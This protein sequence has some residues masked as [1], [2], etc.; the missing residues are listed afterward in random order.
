M[1]GAAALLR[2][3]HSSSTCEYE[4][5]PL[6]LPALPL[7][8]PAHTADRPAAAFLLQ[9]FLECICNS[10][11][12]LPEQQL[13]VRAGGRAALPLNV[14]EQVSIVCPSAAANWSH[15]PPTGVAAQLLTVQAV[16]VPVG[17]VWGQADPW[18]HVELGRQLA[19]YPSG[20]PAAALYK[21]HPS[22]ALQCC[23]GGCVL[24]MAVLVTLLPPSL[25]QWRA[26]WSCRA[27]ATAR[28]WATSG[29]G[30]LCGIAAGG[31]PPCCASHAAPACHPA[32]GTSAPSG[33]ADPT[34]CR[35]C[36]RT[37]RPTWSTRSCSTSSGGTPRGRHPQGAPQQRREQ[38]LQHDS[39]SKPRNSG[40]P[41]AFASRGHQG[42]A[43]HTK[44]V[45]AVSFDS[46]DPLTAAAAPTFGCTCSAEARVSGAA[47]GSTAE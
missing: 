3:L 19:Q 18:E 45:G 37:R 17:I 42:R 25:P 30:E 24:R 10:R 26:L 40:T 13:Q 28:R 9:V 2:H 16:P 47:G 7:R 34:T 6:L 14:G 46:F 27:W 11:G 15:C 22:H 41:A 23:S 39:R 20:Q 12:P 36:L 21:V 31:G 5:P 44:G 29:R 4:R 32:R 33:P 43:L 1:W 35:A 8:L 38:T